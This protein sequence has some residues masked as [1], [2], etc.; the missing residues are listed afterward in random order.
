MLD[1]FKR[2]VSLISGGSEPRCRSG[3]IGTP[4][5]DAS[6]SI[7]VCQYERT[8]FRDGCELIPLRDD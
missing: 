6:M 7:D 3:A 2:T 4:D 8:S 1:L 5:S